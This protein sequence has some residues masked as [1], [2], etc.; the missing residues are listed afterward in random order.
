MR[1]VRL[2]GKCRKRNFVREGVCEIS[3]LLLGHRILVS[4]LLVSLM[5]VLLMKWN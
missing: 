4:L 1:D 3:G 5:I 2:G